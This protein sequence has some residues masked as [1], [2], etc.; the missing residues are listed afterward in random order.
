L[1]SLASLS[2]ADATPVKAINPAAEIASIHWIMV[3]RF[4][5]SHSP[6]SVE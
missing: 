6:L 5:M 2:A 1:A 4:S 3:I